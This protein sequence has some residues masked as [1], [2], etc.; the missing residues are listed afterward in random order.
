VARPTESRPGDGVTSQVEDSRDLQQICTVIRQG[1]SALVLGEAGTVIDSMP[2]AIAQALSGELDCATVVYKGSGKLFFQQMA[3]ALDIPISETKFD[4][5]G[6]EVGEKGLTL[7]QLKEE[8]LMNV[9]GNTLLVLPEARRLTTGIRYW[10]EDAIAA[11]VRVCCFT[12]ANPGRDIFL[13]MIEI[14]LAMPTDAYIRIVMAAEAQRQC[15]PL[16][17]AQLAA[18]QPLAGR[19]PMLARKVVQREKLGIKNQSPE[20]TQYIVIMPVVVALLFSF[21][22]LRFIGM[23]TGNKALYL[24]GGVSLVVAM[25]LKQLG[26]VKGARKRL[27][28]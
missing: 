9:G 15:L 24:V 28:Q 23:G 6:E 22:V 11:G 4:E 12:A 26:Q 13:N 19:N 17:E 2:R 21:A 8:I 27:G 1:H 18:L 10:L 14:E 5:D 3:K 7:E 20:H 25:A 16:T